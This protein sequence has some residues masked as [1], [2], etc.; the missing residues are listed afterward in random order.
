MTGAARV[1]KATPDGYTVM[2][3]GS[4]VLAI[5]QTLYAKPLYN[6]VTDFEHVAMFADSA[7]ILIV[8]KDHPVGSFKEFVEY[9]KANQG[10]FRF[11]AVATVNQMLFAL[12][13]QRLGFGFENVPYKASDQAIT[14]MFEVLPLSPERVWA[15]CCR[16]IFMLS[17]RTSSG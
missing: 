15:T 8:R 12:V 11:G 6:A 14:A 16:R 4:A 7:R 2:L 17:F 1:A 10:K 5:N 9:A 3:S 13:A